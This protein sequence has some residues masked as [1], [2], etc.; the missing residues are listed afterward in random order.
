[1][2]WLI[3]EAERLLSIYQFFYCLPSW[4]VP[5]VHC[6]LLV[7]GFDPVLRKN[8]FEKLGWVPWIF[9]EPKNWYRWFPMI[10]GHGT[11]KLFS[12]GFREDL[13]LVVKMFVH[14]QNRTLLKKTDVPHYN[15]I[16]VLY[17]RMYM[18]FLFIIK[19]IFHSTM[20]T[21]LL[22]FYLLRLY[23]VFTI[24]ILLVYGLFWG[25]I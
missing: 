21:A 5:K 3:Y 14:R 9:M 19:I 25:P 17:S 7:Y 15:S 12:M 13:S 16:S 20:V 24:T 6:T 1:M 11:E 8:D 4:I 23:C 2:T 22:G 10:I 18:V